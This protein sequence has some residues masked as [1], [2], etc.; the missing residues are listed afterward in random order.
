MFFNSYGSKTSTTSLKNHLTNHG[1]YDEA[2][3]PKKRE[4][5]K[6]FFTPTPKTAKLSSSIMSPTMK[7][8]FTRQIALMYALDQAPFNIVNKKG[9]RLFCQ[10]NNI[11]IEQFSNE[12]HVAQAG[13]SD[14]YEFCMLEMKKNLQQAPEYATLVLDCTTDNYRQRA[15]INFLVV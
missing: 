6:S 10:L 9:C 3:N 15:F 7:F 12:R 4:T 8:N 5:I 1:I 2:M 11:N 13:L 14:I